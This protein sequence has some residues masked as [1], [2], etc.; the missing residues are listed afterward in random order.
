MAREKAVKTNALRILDSHHIAYTTHAYLCEDGKIDG[1][2]VAQKVGI[3]PKRVFKTLVT[4][5]AS[6]QF[7]VFVIGVE[8]ELDLKKAAR[9]AQ[10]KNI[11][12]IHVA[13]I[14]KITGY[15]RGGCSPVGMKKAFPTFIDLC[16]DQFDSIVVSAGKIGLQMDLPLQSLVEITGAHLCDLIATP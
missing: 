14:N 11:A 8:D 10:E 5:G 15:I 9:A 7:Y 13:D 1:V 4:Q 12:M 2:S 6:H 3:N 16:A